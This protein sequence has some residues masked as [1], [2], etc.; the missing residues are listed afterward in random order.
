MIKTYIIKIQSWNLVHNKRLFQKFPF[1]WSR[2]TKILNRII[3]SKPEPGSFA[4]EILVHYPVLCSRCRNKSCTPYFR[5]K[6][7]KAVYWIASHCPTEIKREQYAKALQKF[8]QVDIYGDC[9]NLTCPNAHRSHNPC[10]EDNAV[11]Y[12]FYLAFENREINALNFPLVS[13]P[14]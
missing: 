6:K 1:K 3:K 11:I 14:V 8:I 7:S 10:V 4:V 9:G 13:H 2:K 5:K 12:Y